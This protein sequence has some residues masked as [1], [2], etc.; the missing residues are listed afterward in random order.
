MAMLR[1]HKVNMTVKQGLH[2][3]LALFVQQVQHAQLA[4]DQVQHI[5][6]VDEVDVAPIDALLLVLSLQAGGRRH[7]GWKL[8]DQISSQMSY[9]NAV[10]RFLK[11]EMSFASFDVRDAM[12][13]EVQTDRKLKDTP[14]VAAGIASSVSIATPQ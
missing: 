14:P 3:S 10:S 8:S 7:T 11:G 9:I 2:F 4:L 1:S 12:Q 5:L 13:T 6:V